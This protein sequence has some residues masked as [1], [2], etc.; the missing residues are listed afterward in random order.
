MGKNT[1]EC[2]IQLL[3]SHQIVAATLTLNY[4]DPYICDC[5]VMAGGLCESWERCVLIQ[6][7]SFFPRPDQVTDISDVK[8]ITR[9]PRDTKR[10]AV[11]IVFTDDTSRTF[12][13]ESG[14][15][16]FTAH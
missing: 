11:A 5:Q 1:S 3:A 10:Q 6:T 16:T 8:N 2:L 9:L 7:A 12:T 14:T 15:S 4:F 13:C